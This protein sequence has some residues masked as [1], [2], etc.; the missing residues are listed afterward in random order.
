[1]PVDEGSLIVAEHRDAPGGQ[2]PR[3]IPERTVGADPL[4]PILGPGPVDQHHPGEGPFTPGEG[5]GPGQLVRRLADGHL[6]LDEPGRVGVGWRRSVRL[7][8]AGRVLAG[9]NPE[10]GK[11]A[12]V[13]ERV[14]EIHLAAGEGG[15]LAH[16]DYWLLPGHKGLTH[17]L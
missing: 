2:A 15:R 6:H 5:E 10:P 13:V 14:K 4:V 3:Q 16:L 17:R 1:G 12:P 11:P 9:H 7:S 8:L